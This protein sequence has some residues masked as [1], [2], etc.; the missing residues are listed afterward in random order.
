MANRITDR[1]NYALRSLRMA[2][3]ANSGVYTVMSC[4]PDSAHLATNEPPTVTV[5]RLLH[6]INEHILEARRISKQLDDKNSALEA[7]NA[8]LRSRIEEIE[9]KPPWM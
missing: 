2:S 3:E 8:E 4:T 7:E 5:G 1:L 6:D 9:N